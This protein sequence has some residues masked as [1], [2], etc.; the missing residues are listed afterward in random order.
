[1]YAEKTSTAI[2]TSIYIWQVSIFWNYK[3]SGLS[4]VFFIQLQQL[5]YQACLPV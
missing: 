1:M 5:P 2:R 4:Q 3:A